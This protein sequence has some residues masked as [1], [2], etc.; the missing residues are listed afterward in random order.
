[1]RVVKGFR[2]SSKIKVSGLGGLLKF[3][4][5]LLVLV[6]SVIGRLNSLS[7]ISVFSFLDSVQVSHSLD[8][9]TISTFLFSEVSKL[10][11]K[12][13]DVSTESTSSISL[14]LAVTRRSINFSLTTSDL[15]TGGGNLGLQVSVTSVFLIKEETS[16]VNFF[17]KTSKSDQVRL[18]SGFEIVILK[19]LFIGEV[20][21]L[22]LDG[23]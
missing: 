3:S 23:V 15:L 7:A 9:L 8:F 2:G 18:M 12:V 11:R 1:L 13:V 20:A 6:K 5:F 14:L 19:Q 16:I 22:C 21:V 10:V 17:S 4:E